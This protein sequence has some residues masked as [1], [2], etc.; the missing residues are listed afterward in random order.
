[1]VKSILILNFNNKGDIMNCGNY[2]DIKLMCHNMKLYERVH[3][4][5]LRK[6]VIISEEHFG[7]LKGKST[8][9]ANVSLR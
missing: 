3:E 5:R 1:M 6:I 7:F 8:T 4:N 9:E 2:R